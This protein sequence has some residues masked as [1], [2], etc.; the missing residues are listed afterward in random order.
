VGVVAFAADPI[1]ATKCIGMKHQIVVASAKRMCSRGKT[2]E[3][4]GA[5]MSGEEATGFGG[6]GQGED[7]SVAALGWTGR[8]RQ[9]EWERFGPEQIKPRACRAIVGCRTS[10]TIVRRPRPA[11]LIARPRIPPILLRL[12]RRGDKA[13]WGPVAL[14]RGAVERFVSSN[15]RRSCELPLLSGLAHVRRVESADLLGYV[16]TIRSKAA[17][18]L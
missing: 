1:R 16:V 17:D 13:R 6:A 2:L 4:S 9:R 3:G 15:T 10:H 12:Q 14:P 18:Q 7:R 8:G 5:Q 11:H